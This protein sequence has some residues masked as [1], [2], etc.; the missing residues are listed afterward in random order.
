MNANKIQIVDNHNLH[1][2]SFGVYNENILINYILTGHTNEAADFI[3]DT[4]ESCSKSSPENRSQVYSGIFRAIGKVI[5]VK[6][7]RAT[8]FESKTEDEILSDILSQSDE[9]VMQYLLNL[10]QNIAKRKGEDCGNC[11]LYKRTF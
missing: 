4:F 10:T 3:R 6:K 9:S 2:Y 8:D 1:E 11:R 5:K 7:I